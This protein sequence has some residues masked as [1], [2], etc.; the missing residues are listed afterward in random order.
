MLKLQFPS[1]DAKKRSPD[2]SYSDAY[3]AHL[4]HV[5]VS[6]RADLADLHAFVRG[7]GTAAARQVVRVLINGGGKRVHAKAD[8]E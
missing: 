4:Q 1:R 7:I 5:S 3:A 6:L 8:V 2:R